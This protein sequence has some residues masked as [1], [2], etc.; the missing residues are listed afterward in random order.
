MEKAVLEKI[1]VLKRAYK[2]K[3]QAYEAEHEKLQAY[4]EK[5]LDENHIRGSKELLGDVVRILPDS[6]LRSRLIDCLYAL[7]DKEAER[8]AGQGNEQEAAP[9]G[10][11]DMGRPGVC[12]M[13]R[14]DPK[15]LTEIKCMAGRYREKEQEFREEQKKLQEYV[16]DYIDQYG[17]RNDVAKLNELADALPGGIVCFRLREIICFLEFLF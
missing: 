12:G 15:V 4:V 14:H 16:N 2:E 11:R 3:E 9:A 13:P 6:R 1:G 8:R 7:H 17:I 10:G 5:Y